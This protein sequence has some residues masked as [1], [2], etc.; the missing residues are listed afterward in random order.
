M[1][2]FTVYHVMPEFTRDGYFAL[3][4]LDHYTLV[5]TV[6]APELGAVFQFTNHIDGNWTDNPEVVELFMLKDRTRSTSVGDLVSDEL[7][8]FYRVEGCGWS[9]VDVR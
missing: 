8:D 4:P 9:K 3:L 2:R 1:P 7:G 5:A 6:E